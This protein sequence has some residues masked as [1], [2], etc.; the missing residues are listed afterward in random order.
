MPANKYALFRYHIINSRLAKRFPEYPTKEDLRQACE[1]ELYGTDGKH[2]SISTIEKDIFAMKNESNLGYYA[3]IEYSR[4][5]RGYYYSDSGYTLADIPLTEEDMEAIY[6]AAGILSQFKGMKI[7]EQFSDAIDKISDVVKISRALDNDLER[8]NIIQFEK[9][10]YFKG[11]HLLSDLALAIK[12]KK[13]IHL[14]HKGFERDKA[15]DH[16]LHPYLLKEFRNRWYVIGWLEAVKRIRTFGLD[17]IVEMEVLTDKKYRDNT[18][19]NPDDFFRYVFGIS[20]PDGKPVKAVL[21][22]TEAQSKYIETKPLHHS[23]KIVKEI[24]KKDGKYIIVSYEVVPNYE[25]KMQILSYGDQ[26][27][28]LKPKS[29]ADDIRKMIG[30]MA[31]RYRK[32]SK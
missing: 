21:S 15:L 14:K 6:F 7:F 23:Q 28:V 30:K 8:S 22:F 26:V 11:H 18:D 10:P 17:R 31:A 16:I 3:P 2:I 20:M 13:V 5:H 27:E 4:T 25:F 24:E 9:A 29:L 32:S 19:F 1:D 12:N